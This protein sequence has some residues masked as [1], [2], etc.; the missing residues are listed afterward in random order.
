M[1]SALNGAL[2][3]RP[4]MPAAA[5]D[6]LLEVEFV[7]LAIR[8][9]RQAAEIRHRNLAGRRAAHHRSDTEWIAGDA[10]RAM[11]VDIDD[12]GQIFSTRPYAS[13]TASFIISDSVGCGKTVCVSSS[14]VVSKF[15]ATT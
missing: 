2:M 7:H 13:S 4:V 1:L 6:L 10:L 8:D 12:G 15:I 14:S 3:M 5:T 11:C 9:G